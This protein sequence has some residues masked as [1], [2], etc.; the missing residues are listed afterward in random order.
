MIKTYRGILADGGQ[1][2]IRLRTN[3]GDI[4]YRIVNFRIFPSEPGQQTVENTMVVWKVR[5]TTLSASAVVID[6]SDSTMLAVGT[7][8]ESHSDNLISEDIVIFDREVFNQDIYITHTD[9]VGTVACNYYLE[10]EQVPLNE[11]ESTMATLQSLRTLAS[12]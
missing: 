3:R 8:H 4:G 5:Q 2:K 9:T 12:K 1:D 6:F 7:F 10:L 11:N